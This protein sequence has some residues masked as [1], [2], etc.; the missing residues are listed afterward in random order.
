MTHDKTHCHRVWL[1]NVCE[2]GSPTPS[3]RQSDP[4]KFETKTKGDARG[5]RKTKRGLEFRS[6]TTSREREIDET[7]PTELTSE[8]ARNMRR[9]HHKHDLSR[10]TSPRVLDGISEDTWSCCGV[11]GACK[12]RHAYI[13]SSSIIWES[14]A[15]NPEWMYIGEMR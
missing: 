3:I 15:F 11:V 7:E 8:S 2:T 10:I 9:R 13:A 12:A 5:G 4:T 1:R 14:S 6:L